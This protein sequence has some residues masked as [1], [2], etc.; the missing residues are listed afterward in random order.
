M[1]LLRHPLFSLSESEEA[2]AREAALNY[3]SEFSPSHMVYQSFVV[4]LQQLH[5]R[6]RDVTAVALSLSATAAS[7]QSGGGRR[8]M[9]MKHTL[10]SPKEVSISLFSDILAKFSDVLC[11]DG[12]LV[13]RNTP[14][15]SILD[16][17]EHLHRR[18]EL[19]RCLFRHKVLDLLVT[20]SLQYFK[21]Q[22]VV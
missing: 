19:L 15:S 11:S 3:V 10:S 17:E 16:A 5:R 9:L 4:P 6:L 7:V 20:V 13:Y 8:S 22:Q 18:M 12:P 21:S 1:H 2:L 14:R